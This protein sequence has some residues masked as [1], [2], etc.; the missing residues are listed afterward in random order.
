M[1]ER[2]S[3]EHPQLHVRLSDADN[4]FLRTVM[5]MGKLNK[6]DVVVGLFGMARKFGPSAVIEA[7][8][9]SQNGNSD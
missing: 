3:K 9:H 8:R 2:K 1:S 6:T 4:A 5:D 7:I